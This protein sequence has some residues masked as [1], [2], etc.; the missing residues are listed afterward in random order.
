[1]EADFI[2]WFE[3]CVGDWHSHRRY[4][5]G[6]NLTPDVLETTFE[7]S[8]TGDNTFKLN[9]GSARNVGEM[10]FIVRD[11]LL[12]RDKGYYTDLPTTSKMELIDKD[13]VVFYTSYGGVDYREEIR[14]LHKD[15]LRLRQTIGFKDNKVNVVGQY[16]EV[17]NYL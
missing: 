6:D 10:N 16:Y 13:T 12:E 4:L 9:W 14:L 3:R 11:G 2:S 1:M 8:Q 17:R 7:I 15:N 5:Y